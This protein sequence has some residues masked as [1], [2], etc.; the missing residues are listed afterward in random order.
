M[1][2]CSPC[3]PLEGAIHNHPKGDCPNWWL[4]SKCKCK[5]GYEVD[6]NA[7]GYSV[8][9]DPS[10]GIDP[11][12]DNKI[13]EPR[14]FTPT[15]LVTKLNKEEL[16]PKFGKH[17]SIKVTQEWRWEIDF[18]NYNPTPFKLYYDD[19]PIGM[20]DQDFD[21]PFGDGGKPNFEGFMPYDECTVY[22]VKF[23]RECT[24]W[25]IDV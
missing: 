21:E 17:Y 14:S 12:Y 6:S 4:D 9:S 8:K 15:D 23:I 19:T 11:D 1:I 22:Q 16:W 5:K 10:I 18:T 24:G 13:P 20:L 3:F 7:V 25:K 2:F